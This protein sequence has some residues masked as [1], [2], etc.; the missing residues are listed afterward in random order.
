[1]HRRRSKQQKIQLKKS[2]PQHFLGYNQ[3]PLY[4]GIVYIVLR[5]IESLK[6]EGLVRG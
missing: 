4:K 6:E 2:Y 5:H 1:M 3:I